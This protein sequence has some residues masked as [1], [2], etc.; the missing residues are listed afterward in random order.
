[1]ILQNCVSDLSDLI[2]QLAKLNFYLLKSFEMAKRSN[3]INLYTPVK[4]TAIN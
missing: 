2:G 1:V 4:P 3:E